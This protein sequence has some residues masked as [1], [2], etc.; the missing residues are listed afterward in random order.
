MTLGDMLSSFDEIDACSFA[1]S[2]PVISGAKCRGAGVDAPLTWR[3]RFE[4]KQER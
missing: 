4:S 2:A 1:S 3:L